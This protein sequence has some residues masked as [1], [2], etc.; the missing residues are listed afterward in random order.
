MSSDISHQHL[1]FCLSF[2]YLAGYYLY[3]VDAK[4][5]DDD[6]DDSDDDDEVN[7]GYEDKYGEE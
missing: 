5:G 6:N 3:L 7:I 4:G 2:V 1:S